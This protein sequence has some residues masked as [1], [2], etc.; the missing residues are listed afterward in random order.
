MKVS[1]GVIA[2]FALSVL[3]FLGSVGVILLKNA[4]TDYRVGVDPGKMGLLDDH[5]FIIFSDPAGAEIRMK[6]GSD[7][8]DTEGT[9][10]GNT[11]SPIG[12]EDFKLKKD[13][14]P[15]RRVKFFLKMPG[16]TNKPV[17]LAVSDLMTGMYPPPSVGILT[18]EPNSAWSGAWLRH[19][20]ATILGLASA[21]G[22]CLFGFLGGAELKRLKEIEALRDQYPDDDYVGNF[23]SDYRVGEPLGKGGYGTVYKAHVGGTRAVHHAI[24]ISKYD[25][26]NPGLDK[27]L[28]DRFERE[29]HLVKDLEHRNIGKVIEFDS[30][31]KYSWVVMPLYDGGELEK[32][33]EEDKLGGDDVLH[34]ARGIADGLTM[35]HSKDICHRDLKPANVMI[36]QGEA[37]IID[38]GLA[39]SVNSKTL[40]M[41]GAMM[42][43]PTYMP[44]E[45]LMDSKTVTHKA[46]QYAF[47]VILFEM[48]TKGKVP[49][50]TPRDGGEI[51]A[52][53]Q[54]KLM[55]GTK[56]LREV[57]PGQSAELEEVLARMTA[58]EAEDRY[59]SVMDAYLAFEAAYNTS[60]A[61]ASR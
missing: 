19:K 47:G 11:N 23:I 44:P 38:F 3:V 4:P 31:Q 46:D 2:G 59:D 8:S 12:L 57:D 43:T 32:L 6:N 17:D 45:Q 33:I 9:R 60:G 5:R 39:R 36:H 49:F 13:V 61:V 40:T 30:T 48:L 54:E 21:V 27:E 1:K 28:R 25:G 20:P 16:Y 7:S 53:V 24:K 10:V 15:D 50:D 26:I 51:M 37:V 29:M 58:S 14:D 56:K 18:M 52:L 22:I 55:K 41:E 35:A 34:Y 42:G